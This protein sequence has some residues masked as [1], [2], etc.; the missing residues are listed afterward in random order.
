MIDRLAM[1]SAGTASVDDPHRR[2]WIFAN[3]AAW[4]GLIFFSLYYLTA[5]RFDVLFAE[6]ARQVDFMIWRFVPSFIFDHARYPAA[7]TGDWIH[8][9]FPYLPSAAAMML[10]LSWPAE[11]PA[12]AIWLVIQLLAFA[13]VLWTGL[14]LSG[15]MKLRARW[16]IAIAAVLLSENSLSWDFR[17]HNTNLIY[18]A[19]VLLG[20]QA[21]RTW[22][23][24]CLLALSINLKLYSGLVPL[25]LTWRRE[26]RLAVATC[27]A[28][29]LIAVL[30]PA[31]VYGPAAYPQLIADWFAQIRYTAAVHS[32]GT[33]ALIRSIATL[34]GAD[35][36]AGIVSLTLR[37]TQ[38]AWLILVVWYYLV[39]HRSQPSEPAAYRQAR[40]ADICIALIA[41][42]PLSTWFIPYHAVVML[43][44]YMILLTVAVADGSP[45]RLR[46]IAIS[47]CAAC[48]GVHFAVRDWD[49]RGLV[50]LVSFVFLLL[51]LAAVRCM[52]DS[53]SAE[54]KLHSA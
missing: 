11:T 38:A 47:A 1:P 20:L 29:V 44:A 35:P 12:F 33:A 4:A 45:K 13:L 49:Y 25:V 26:Y 34:I 43:P 37:A 22:L 19:L 32:G 3:A 21:G 52:S 40:L 28:A 18:L 24:A 17:N 51:A 2:T 54:T 46:A 50:F 8:T 10:P 23:A 48:Q 7:V 9:V 14:R 6:K 36:A 42:L 27:A 16:L 30:L 39:T 41:P 53:G 31:I 5:F 15:A